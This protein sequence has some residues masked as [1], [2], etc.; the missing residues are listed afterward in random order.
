MIKGD[1]IYQVLLKHDFDLFRGDKGIAEYMAGHLGKFYEDIVVATEG[2]NPFLGDA[3]TNL[4]KQELEFLHDICVEIPNILTAFENGHIRDAY[5][6][7]SVLFDRMKPYLLSRYSWIGNGGDFYRIRSGDFRIK[8]PTESKKKK[9]ELFHI[10]RPLRNR[11]GAYR[12][13]VAGYPC[14]Y[15]ASNR[16]LAW[17]ECGMPRQFSYCQLVITE[18]GDYALKLV[19]LSH[20]PIEFLSGFTTWVLNARR[21]NKDD[22]ELKKYYDVLIKYIITYPLA[23]ACSVKVKNRG[24]NFVE[25]Y[26]FPQL[27]MHWIRENDDIDGVRY[28][29]SLNSTL[30]QGMGAVNV[31][32]P[33]KKFREDGLDEKL[34]AKIKV[35]DIGYLDVSKEFK[36]YKDALDAIKDFKDYLRIYI[37]EAQYAGDYVIELIELCECIIK[38]YTALMD[39]DYT[40]SEL[41]FT[42]IDRLYDYA[43]LIYRCRE[44]KV[45]ECIDRALPGQK[46]L[47]DPA[48]IKEH[49]EEFHKLTERILKKHTVF[50]FSFENL[51]NLENI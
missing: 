17:F 27:F 11:I 7:S 22:N 16:E 38:T 40:N 37:I 46:D 50:D 24:S 26:V 41:V 8:E 30:V 42:Y 14:L 18:D 5:V 39:D 15:L 12:Y 25:E 23:A 3:F 13:S 35:S 1:S 21:S 31:A 45:K 34:T 2:E 9:A 36:R 48:I 6:N 47:V 32:L 20:R 4:L 28:K 29:S 19:D 49:F 43:D 44:I 10:K 33:V 51:R